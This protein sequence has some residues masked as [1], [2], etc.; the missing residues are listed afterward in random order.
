VISRL[1]VVVAAPD[2]TPAQALLLQLLPTAVT[3]LAAAQ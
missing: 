1:Y 3:K 2:N